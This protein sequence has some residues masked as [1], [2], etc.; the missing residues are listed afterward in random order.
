MEKLLGPSVDGLLLLAGCVVAD[1]VVG[2]C[3]VGW[4]L[5]LCSGVLLLCSPT[6]NTGSDEEETTESGAGPSLSAVTE[7]ETDE[8]EWLQD[9]HT[10][11]VCAAMQVQTRVWYT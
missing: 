4:V 10:P 9:S 7:P 8:D 2:W 3:F 11:Y 1:L 6:D 5:I